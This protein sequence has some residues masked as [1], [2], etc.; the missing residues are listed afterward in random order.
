MDIFGFSQEGGGRRRNRR[1]RRRRN[2]TGS[3]DGGGGEEGTDASRAAKGEETGEGK[4][5]RQ[6]RCR[7][8][9]CSLMEKRTHLEMVLRETCNNTSEIFKKM[10]NKE[11][12]YDAVFPGCFC[13]DFLPFSEMNYSTLR[14]R[15]RG[16]PTSHPHPNSL[17]INYSTVKQSKTARR[18]K[19]RRRVSRTVFYQ[20][21]NIISSSKIFNLELL[22]LLSTKKPFPLFFFSFLS[23]FL[24]IQ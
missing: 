5:K 17:A 14:P 12:L 18:K 8:H 6:L 4:K 19:S 21:F 10:K 7:L 15:E 2:N 9:F 13:F 23:S 24:A 16:F 11:Q 22:F 3:S 20:Y 1:R